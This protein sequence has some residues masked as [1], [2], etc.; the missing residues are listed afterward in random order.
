MTDKE[1]IEK[2]LEYANSQIEMQMKLFDGSQSMGLS[3]LAE[4]TKA[5][6]AQLRK[7]ISILSQ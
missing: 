1:K 7:F 6:I 3:H 2:A 5:S 4:T